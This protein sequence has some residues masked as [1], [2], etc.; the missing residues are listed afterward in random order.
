VPEADQV[1]VRLAP[2]HRQLALYVVFGVT[3]LLID[4][5]TFL[6]L[7]HAGLSVLMANPASRTF[8][9]VIGYLLNGSM[10]FRGTDGKRHLNVG[11][12]LRFVAL[13][14]ALTAASTLLVDAGAQLFGTRWLAIVKMLVEGGLA[15]ISF[16][17]QKIWVYRHR[18]H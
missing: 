17:A 18:H 7:V 12:F 9:A 15:V 3:Q 2:V 4:W 5:A 14:V 10:T 16:L 11:S 13:F 6:L 8:A 1:P